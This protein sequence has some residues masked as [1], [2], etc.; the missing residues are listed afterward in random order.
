MCIDVETVVSPDS[1][2]WAKFGGDNPGP[3]VAGRLGSSSWVRA[4]PWL[5][6]WVCC[7]NTSYLS[8]LITAGEAGFWHLLRRAMGKPPRPKC[9]IALCPL[10]FHLRTPLLSYQIVP[11][12]K[13]IK[14]LSFL[15]SYMFWDIFLFSFPPTLKPLKNI[16]WWY[17]K[18]CIN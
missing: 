16:F 5:Q 18:V 12:R 9:H 10:G 4:V 14:A 15:T 7:I 13:T 1:W 11:W 6:L 2:V 8:S 3:N 17:F